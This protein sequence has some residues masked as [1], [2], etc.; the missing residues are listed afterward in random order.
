MNFVKF[1]C[2]FVALLSPTNIDFID[3]VISLSQDFIHSILVINIRD[4]ICYLIFNIT[5]FSANNYIL[6]DNLKFNLLASKSVILIRWT[7]PYQYHYG[8]IHLYRFSC[9]VAYC[10]SRK[11]LL[12]KISEKSEKEITII[13][14]KNFLF[15]LLF[16]HG[17]Y[18][19]IVKNLI[20]THF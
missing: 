19:S 13:K 12:Q 10:S 18:P 17:I 5:S 6:C 9:L 8:I 4:L 14:I 11:R 3:S 20:K 15:P 16:F 1:L 2:R 7:L